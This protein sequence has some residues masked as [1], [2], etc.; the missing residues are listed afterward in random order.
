M[1]K[2]VGILNGAFVSSVD[3]LFRSHGFKIETHPIKFGCDILVLTGGG[4]ISPHLYGEKPIK[5]I[6]W[7]DKR[8]SYERSMIDLYKDCPKIGICRGGQLLNVWSGGSMWQD[9]DRHE[10]S[11][12]SYDIKAQKA[13]K[14]SSLHH[15]MMKPGQGADVLLIADNSTYV[16][17]STGVLYKAEQHY[18]DVECIYYPETKSFCYQGHPEIGSEEEKTW[19]FQKIQETLGV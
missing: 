17:G 19:F 11:H 3:N 15:Q 4:D 9:T 18:D 8:D 13:F 7:S 2:T 14:T 16:E 5:G 12:K 6:S 10:G 1:S